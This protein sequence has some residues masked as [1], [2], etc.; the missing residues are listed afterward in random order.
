MKVKIVLVFFSFFSPRSDG[1]EFTKSVFM[2][3]LLNIT[4][5]GNDKTE[6][7]NA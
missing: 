5:M 3:T 6:A 4:T 7:Q 1:S 2:E